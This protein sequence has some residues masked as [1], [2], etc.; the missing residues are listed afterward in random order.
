MTRLESGDERQQQR[1]KS[2]G[3]DETSD[4]QRDADDDGDEE[5]VEEERDMPPIDELE[6]LILEAYNN[7]QSDGEF[8]FLPDEVAQKLHQVAMMVRLAL[9][10]GDYIRNHLSLWQPCYCC[11][12]VC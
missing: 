2:E 11:Q 8:I 10:R 12:T 5:E 6:N 4:N 3:G 7:M 1:V 9:K